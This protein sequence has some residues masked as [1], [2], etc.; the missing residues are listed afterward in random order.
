MWSSSHSAAL[1][2]LPAASSRA[3]ILASRPLLR[4][5]TEAAASRAW[6]MAGSRSAFWVARRPPRADALDDGLGGQLRSA[7]RASGTPTRTRSPTPDHADG[8][9]HASTAGRLMPRDRSKTCVTTS[10]TRLGD[11]G[12]GLGCEGLGT[13]GQADADLG[14][15]GHDGVGDLGGHQDLVGQRLRLVGEGLP[16]GRGVGAD[17]GAT[18]GLGHRLQRVEGRA[19]LRDGDDVHAHVTLAERGGDVGQLGVGG[20][21]AVGED[22]DAPLALVA[23]DVDGCEDAVVETRLLGQGQARPGPCGRRPGPGWA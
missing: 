23:G 15:S 18:T 5:S 13:V 11:R 4:C 1:T 3:A 12:E 6:D 17:H 16:E 8:G 22:Q 19:P 10:S 9:V 2:W 21:R 14:L 20:V 7:W